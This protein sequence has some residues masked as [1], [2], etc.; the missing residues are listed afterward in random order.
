MVIGFHSGL[1][2]LRGRVPTPEEWGA[3]VRFKSHRVPRV[4]P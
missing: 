3:A 1:M 4:L 2:V